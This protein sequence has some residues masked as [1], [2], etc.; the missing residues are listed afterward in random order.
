MNTTKFRLIAK[1]IGW[2]SLASIGMVGRL[3]VICM[4]I[5]YFPMLG[6]AYELA[7]G[8]WTDLMIDSII[9]ASMAQIIL[10][11]MLGETI[12]YRLPRRIR[13]QWD[14]VDEC[15]FGRFDHKVYH[16]H[17][18]IVRHNRQLRRQKT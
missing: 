13:Y 4:L 5:L 1:L 10:T 14:Y 17:R 7:G 15:V 3:F 8:Q 12:W 18:A 11:G 16:A 2:G 9:G 6:L